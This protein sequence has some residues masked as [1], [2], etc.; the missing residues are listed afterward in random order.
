M[1]RVMRGRSTEKNMLHGSRGGKSRRSESDMMKIDENPDMLDIH[2][3]INPEAYL[4]YHFALEVGPRFTPEQVVAESQ[5]RQVK[6]H[7]PKRLRDR[8]VCIH[9]KMLEMV[10]MLVRDG[11]GYT[12]SPD[13]LQLTL[14]GL[15]HGCTDEELASAPKWLLDMLPKEEG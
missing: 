1:H 9:L 14:N 8:S 10:G 12:V 6:L 13:S 2:T 7:S 3:Y 4:V 11:D 5:K 15:W